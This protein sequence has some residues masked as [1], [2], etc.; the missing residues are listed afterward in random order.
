MKTFLTVLL[1]GS[2]LF[3]RG[4]NCC[5]LWTPNSWQRWNVPLQ[6]RDGVSLN[7]V[8]QEPDQKISFDRNTAITFSGSLNW[9]YPVQPYLVPEHYECNK[10]GYAAIYEKF[11][12]GYSITCKKVQ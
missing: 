9:D 2:A 11:E 3:A 12:G 1:L 5:T 6:R 4:Q 10:S 8:G 7:I